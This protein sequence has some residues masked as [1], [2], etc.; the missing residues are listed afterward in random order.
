VRKSDSRSERR[1]SRRVNPPMDER[2]PRAANS[3][4]ESGG[5]MA[6][7]VSIVEGG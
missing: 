6:G 7:F 1:E 4:G 5:R 3:D 2:N